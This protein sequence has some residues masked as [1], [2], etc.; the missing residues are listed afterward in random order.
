MKT[1]VIGVKR[2]KGIGKESG[3]PYDMCRA[4]CL[5]PIE[6][7]SGEKM[8]IQGFGYEVAEVNLDPEALP[9]FG[10]L[11]FP[12]H[13]NLEVEPRPYRGKLEVFVVGFEQISAAAVKVA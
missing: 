9:A 11:K 4:I 10:N 13:L 7:M 1:T 3:N 12:C 8:S 2:V 5:S 6:P